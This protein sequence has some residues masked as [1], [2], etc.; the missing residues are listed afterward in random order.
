[1]PSEKI[2]QAAETL[3]SARRT[4]TQ[5]SDLPPELR[6]TSTAE[7]YA[8]Q[9]EVARLFGRIGGWKVA[10]PKGNEAHRATPIPATYVIPSGSRWPAPGPTRIEVEL[11]VKMRDSLPPRGGPYQPAEVLGA[12]ASAHI[13][14]ELLAARF[15][16]RKQVA[17]L[18]LL[19]DGQSNGG[20]VAGA[21]ICDWTTR[22]LAKLEMTL[23]V[24]AEV[25]TTM[26]AGNS[27][28]VTL[29]ALVWLANHAAEHA[30]GLLEGQVILTGARVGP[31]SV[32][33]SRVE[34][35]TG[36][37]SVSVTLG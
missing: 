4:G 26:A 25:N 1:L 18:T 5:I 30:G 31:V 15:I 24:D 16:D 7:A 23:L 6:P 13:A 37:A 17:P 8:I 34:A 19:A 12:I 36:D 14:F 27:F 33:P 22:N 11:A 10:I 20:L 21:A 2:H 28:E 35:L 9:Y 32:P 3:A 29:N